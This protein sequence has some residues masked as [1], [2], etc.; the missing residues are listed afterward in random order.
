MGICLHYVIKDNTMSR[1]ITIQNEFVT[2]SA[3][4]LMR[5]LSETSK[6]QYLHTFK[7]WDAYCYMNDLPLSSITPDIVAEFL[8]GDIAHKTKLARL[9]HLRNL[10]RAM[11]ANQP[12]NVQVESLMKRMA[13]FKVKRSEEE[14]DSTETLLALTPRQVKSIFSLFD[15]NTKIDTRN[16]CMMA[17][18]FYCGLR[19]SE[20]VRLKWSDIDIDDEM[21]TVR[22]G[23]G[24]KKRTIPILGGI[25]Y[26]KTW[27]Y[28]SIGRTWVFC[29][30]YK[31][32][33]MQADKPISANSAWRVIKDVAT[34]LDIENLS[35]HDARRTLITNLLNEGASVPDVQFIAGHEKPETTLGYAKV[36]DANEVKKRIQDKIPY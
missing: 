34:R 13:M 28:L 22:H 10:L 26:I 16:R 3:N 5:S 32:D 6:R 18:L 20:L 7:E 29:G 35:T 8:R 33:R 4:D 24:D 9:S 23:K 1:E 36:K 14:K 11:H 15:T 21:L 12:D 25:E 17:I 19:R 2:Q 31:G 30:F 27:F